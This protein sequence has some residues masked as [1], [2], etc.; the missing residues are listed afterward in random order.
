VRA[1]HAVH[2]PAPHGIDITIGAGGWQCRCARAF[3]VARVR[4][5]KQKQFGGAMAHA[6]PQ[7][8]AARSAV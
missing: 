4:A 1:V 7:V 8:T 5:L 2:A 3:A 6:Q